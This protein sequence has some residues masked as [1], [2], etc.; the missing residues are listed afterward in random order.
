MTLRHGCLLLDPALD[1]K[2]RSRLIEKEMNEQA[3]IIS[4]LRFLGASQSTIEQEERRLKELETAVFNDFRRDVIKK[5]RRQSVKVRSDATSPP[6]GFKIGAERI[7][8]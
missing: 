3:K 1:A 7:K 8:S 5:L 4:D 6:E 2:K